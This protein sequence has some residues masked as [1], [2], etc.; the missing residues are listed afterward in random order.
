M[1]GQLPEAS[2]MIGQLPEASLMIGQSPEAEASLMIGLVIS[3]KS[4]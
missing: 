3:K 1:I 4:Q 2:L